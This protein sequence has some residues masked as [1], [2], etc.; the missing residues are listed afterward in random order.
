VS[1]IRIGLVL[2]SGGARG[3]AHIVAIETLE[4]LGIRPVQIAGASIGAIIGAAYASGMSG[5]QLRS[6]FLTQFRNRSD[7]MGR[8]FQTRVGK[9]SDIWREGL[10]NPVLVDG[11]RVLDTFFPE[12]FRESFADLAIPLTI[13]AA[14]IH[15]LE[16]VDLT[17]GALK[18]AI[19]ASMAIPGLVRPVVH[20]GKVMIDGG[21]ID[22]LPVRAITEPVDLILAIDI[23]RAAQREESAEIPGFIETLTRAFDLMQLSLVES[24]SYVPQAPYHRVKARVD[25][26][27]ALDF[28]RPKKVFTASASISGEIERVIEAVQH[29]KRVAISGP[30]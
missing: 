2:G 21:A 24:Q 12:F 3:L 22:P 1:D 14:D 8:L 27:A 6:H 28:F 29:V 30:L 25:Q 13:V 18:P 20:Q 5:T 17:E 23:S 16:R 11:E 15:R 7:V 19:A 26:F 9:F 4:R 10:T